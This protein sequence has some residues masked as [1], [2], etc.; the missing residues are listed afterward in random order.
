M[1]TRPSGIDNMSVIVRESYFNHAAEERVL[2]RIRTE[3]EVD[4]LSVARGLALVMV[5]GEGMHHTI[6]LA[7]RA[8]T[9]FFPRQRQ[10]RDD[11]SGVERGQYDVRNHSSG[12]SRGRALTLR[13]VFWRLIGLRRPNHQPQ[14]GVVN[15]AVLGET[16]RKL[17]ALCADDWHPIATSVHQV[18]PSKIGRCGTTR[19]QRHDKF[20]AIGLP[21]V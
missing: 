6:G 9:C 15:Q 1:S 11:Q 2:R 17:L 14:L 7:A 20:I 21:Q 19:Q 3:L 18:S 4:E 13:R 5:V 10:H 8:C 16:A 12:H